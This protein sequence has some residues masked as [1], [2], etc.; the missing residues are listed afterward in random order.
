MERVQKAHPKKLRA[1]GESII[2][3]VTSFFADSQ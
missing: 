2:V 1:I 3:T